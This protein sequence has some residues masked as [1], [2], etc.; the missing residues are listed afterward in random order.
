MEN[1]PRT[2]LGLPELNWRAVLG[3]FAAL[4]TCLFFYRQLGYL[5]NGEYRSPLLTFSEETVGAIAG[6]VVFPLAYLVAI[7]FP[8]LSDMWRRNLAVHLVAVCLIS[9]VHTTV[10]AGLRAVFFP[11]LGFAKVSYGYLPWRYPM[12]FAHLFIFYWAGVSLVYLFHEIRFARQ[13]ELRE[14]KLEATLSEAQLQNLRLQLE[15]HFLFN[16]LNAISAA[17]YENPRMA[18]EMIGRLSELLRQLLKSDRS[19]EISLAREME[20]LKLYTRIMEARLEHR[21]K[22]AFQI[23]DAA[24]DALVPQLILQPLVENAIQHGMD[25]RTFSVDIAVSA[26]RE[27]GCVRLVVRDHGPGIRG[28]RS[29]GSGIGLGNT[30]ERLRRLYGDRQRL[31]IRDAEDGGA[32]VEL[33]LPFHL[34]AEHTAG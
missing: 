24:R 29:E 3:V 13:R 8:L 9:I 34:A 22:L 7:R 5:A 28:G 10:I 23:D 18:D 4:T 11:V 26:H 12:E 32:I 20:L 17:L 14:A 31:E 1:Q 33:Q 6:F 25:P 21:L 30:A 19:Q 2:Y 27:N 16:A 15:P